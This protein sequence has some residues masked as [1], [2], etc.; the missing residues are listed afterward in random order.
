MRLILQN[1]MFN[2]RW[3]FVKSDEECINQY[4]RELYLKQWT[5]SFKNSGPTKCLKQCISFVIVLLG[6]NVC[7][8]YFG[9]GKHFIHKMSFLTNH[10][11]LV[12]G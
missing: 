8:Y 4:E 11:V 2:V 6:D 5:S 7:G 9:L 12:Y 1:K 3:S 10:N